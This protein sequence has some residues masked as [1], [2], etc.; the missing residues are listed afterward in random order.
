MNLVYSKSSV[1]IDHYF[2]EKR[3]VDF[4]CKR[5][6]YSLIKRIN[7]VYKGMEK[8]CYIFIYIISFF[9]WLGNIPLNMINTHIHIYAYAIYTQWN[10]IWP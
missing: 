10:I 2:L 8:R 5:L 6:K 1:S 7:I 9:L 4:R 3:T